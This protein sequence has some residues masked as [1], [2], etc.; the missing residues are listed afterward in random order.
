MPLEGAEASTEKIYCEFTEMMDYA[1]RFISLSTLEYRSVWWRLFNA[2][3]KSDWQNALVLVELLFSLPASYGTV[4][5]VFSMSKVIKTDKRSI[6]SGEF[7]DDLLLLNTDK[8]P[9]TSFV[10]DQA[11]DLWWTD[12][13][14]RPNQRPRKK[15]KK[16]SKDHYCFG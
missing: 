10:A 7:F 11:I 3:S 4:E 13:I 1:V 5:R 9:L 2:P 8:V 12:K 6:L 14:R 16:H 15:Y